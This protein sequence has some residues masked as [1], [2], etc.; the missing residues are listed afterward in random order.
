MFGLRCN[1]FVVL[2]LFIPARRIAFVTIFCLEI[3]GYER[4]S[5]WLATVGQ[6]VE[7]EV[8]A[9]VY[10]NNFGTGRKSSGLNKKWFC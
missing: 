1:P 4:K 7:I 8:L 10:A 6:E 3:D 9:C 5:G 2:L